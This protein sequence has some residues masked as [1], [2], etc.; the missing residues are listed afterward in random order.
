MDA[1][2]YFLFLKYAYEFYIQQQDYKKF[3]YETYT[4]VPEAVSENIKTLIKKNFDKYD[5]TTE[6]LTL[7]IADVQDYLKNETTYTLHPGSLP[8]GEEFVSYFLLKSKTGYCVHYA[9]AATVIFRSL[10][11]P[12]R[13]VEGYLATKQ[14]LRDSYQ[15][16]ERE[17]SLKLTDRNAHAWV[18]VYVEGYGWL[19]VEVTK[20]YTNGGI[21]K[22]ENEKVPTTVPSVS[23]QPQATKTPS[24]TQSENEQ[25]QGLQTPMKKG[26]DWEKYIPFVKWIV[27]FLMVCLAVY[28]RKKLVECYRRKKEEHPDANQRAA[29]CYSQIEKLLRVQRM[30]K[31]EEE[32][33][34][35]IEHGSIVISNISD[36]EWEMLLEVMNKY[37]FSPEGLSFSEA[38]LVVQS[39]HRVR[40]FCY[41]QQSFLKR[42][43]YEYIRCL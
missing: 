12:A 20:G 7:A 19:P 18:E 29:Y 2:S 38:E 36:R 23:K 15:G 33:R 27:G 39:Y 1:D 13:Y 42:C 28:G 5:G 14:Q 25:Q 37:A 35:L 40:Q 8:E 34:E 31:K 16:E 21:P 41:H 26:V 10:G 43:Y 32:L 24:E 22:E 17:S 4:Q 30:C 9:S 11:I 6:A 3:V